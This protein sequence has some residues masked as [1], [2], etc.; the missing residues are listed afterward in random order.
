MPANVGMCSC[1]IFGCMTG[2]GSGCAL[3]SGDPN[4][5]SSSGNDYRDVVSD[6]GIEIVG[7]AMIVVDLSLGV[8][9][10]LLSQGWSSQ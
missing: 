5:C 10:P 6:D 4:G 8:Q 9:H 7:G 3:D 1:D 2:R